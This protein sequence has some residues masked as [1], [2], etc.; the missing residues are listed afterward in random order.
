MRGAAV[1]LA[2]LLVTS[3]ARHEEEIARTGGNPDRGR[4]L[5]HKYGCSGCHTI[6]GLDGAVGNTGP[7]LGGVGSRP[8]L[9]GVLPN[10]PENLVAMIRAPKRAQP[11]TSMPDMGVGDQDARDL[12]AFLYT[13]R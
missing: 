4:Q 7:H 1:L 8:V 11:R 2:L 9:L 3:C 10:T 5:V 13:V 12:A 6:P